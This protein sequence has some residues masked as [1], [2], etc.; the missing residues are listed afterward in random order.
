MDSKQPAVSVLMSVR[1]ERRDFLDAAL[2]SIVAQDFA[3]FEVVLI[4]D[5]STEQGTTAALEHWAARDRRIR[6][7]T[8]INRGLTRSLNLGLT[9]CRAKLIARHDSDDWSSPQRLA[10]QVAFMEA[11]PEVG[12]LGTQV[13]IHMENGAELWVSRF[14]QMHADIVDAFERLNPFCHGATMFRRDVIERVGGYRENL[15]CSQDYDLFW[16]LSEQTQTANLPS[17]LYHHRRTGSSVSAKRAA[18]QATVATLTR[19]LARQRRSGA[20]SLQAAEAEVLR[21]MSGVNLE[22]LADRK[23]AESLLLAGDFDA[24]IR[25]FLELLVRYPR[26]F[27]S[28]AATLRAFLFILMPWA[29]RQLFRA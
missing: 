15:P 29:R 28:Y 16:R 9:R 12:L 7:F 14:P 4:D 3:N 8:E 6:L 19:I 25:A 18:E 23:R 13:I 21:T 20:E 17:A 1:N 2:G 10:Q 26:N 5:G 22:H 24:A 11:H 27:A